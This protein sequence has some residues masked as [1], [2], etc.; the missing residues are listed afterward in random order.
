MKNDDD[1][2][3][4]RRVARVARGDEAALRQLAADHLPWIEAHVRKRMSAVAR[5]DGDTQDFVQ[6]T[7]LDVLRSGPHF[8]IDDAAA[9]R[10]LLARIVENNL[11]DRVRYLHREQR[12]LRR[13]RPLP[14]DS[15][16]QLDAPLRSVTQPPSAADR[17][18]RQ[19]WL[20]LAVELL[21][22]EDREIIRLRDW[23]GTSFAALGE[24]LGVSEEA[25]RK[26]YARA[27]P[28]LAEKVDLLRRGQWRGALSAD[29]AG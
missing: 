5:R 9:F 8:A 14:T 17:N 25:A 16:L 2:S 22:A 29:D 15:V 10:A 7:L 24:R 13:Q 19:E 27:L 4:S 3:I 26:R 1:A 28:R 23:D 21:D 18:E 20:R 12:D 11:I 6:E